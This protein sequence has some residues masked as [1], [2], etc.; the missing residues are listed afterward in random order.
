MGLRMAIAG[1]KDW[2]EEGGGV[3]KRGVYQKSVM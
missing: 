2:E 3:R 1:L